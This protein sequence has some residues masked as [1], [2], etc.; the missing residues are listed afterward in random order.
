MFF[1]YLCGKMYIHSSYYLGVS[2]GPLKFLSSRK[3]WPL[4]DVLEKFRYVL[5]NFFTVARMLGFS[6]KCSRLFEISSIVLSRIFG[7]EL[8]CIS[9][10]Y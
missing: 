7:T 1:V 3:I 4:L 8:K 5:A 2:N 9:L 10:R 6:L